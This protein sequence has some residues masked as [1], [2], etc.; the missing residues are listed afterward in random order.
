MPVADRIQHR[1]ESDPLQVEL[2]QKRAGEE[3][4]QYLLYAGDRAG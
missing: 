4:L 1:G 3:C 2:Y